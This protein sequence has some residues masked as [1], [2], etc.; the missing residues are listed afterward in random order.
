MSFGGLTWPKVQLRLWENF[1]TVWLGNAEAWEH[2]IVEGLARA[3]GGHV[4][5]GRGRGKN[6]RKVGGLQVP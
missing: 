5:V 3:L 6:Q 1:G 4:P 2:E